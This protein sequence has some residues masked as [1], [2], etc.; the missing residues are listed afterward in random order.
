MLTITEF[1]RGVHGHQRFWQGKI[2]FDNDYS[3]GGEAISPSDFGLMEITMVT[4]TQGVG[5][6]NR[7]V[8]WNR[9]GSTLRVKSGSTG[10][11]LSEGV[12]AANVDC[13]LMVYGW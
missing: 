4:L 12:S 11:Q 6:I 8:H 10:V 5:T 2:Q 3:N 13:Y 1:D 7:E 9:D